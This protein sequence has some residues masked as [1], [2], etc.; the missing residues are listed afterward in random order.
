MIIVLRNNIDFIFLSILINFDSVIILLIIKILSKFV[1]IIIEFTV[2]EF[3]V[4]EQF[5]INQ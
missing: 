1:I 4:K 2:L 5:I 3:T